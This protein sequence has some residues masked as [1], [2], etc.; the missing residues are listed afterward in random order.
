MCPDRAPS[1]PEPRPPIRIGCAGWSIASAHAA[2]FGA[3]D[4]MLARYATRF[5]T[6]EINSSFYRHHQ[7]RT[8]ER[9]AAT[10]PDGFRFSAKLPRTVTHDARL[11]GARDVLARFL[12][13]IAALGHK[14]GGVLVQL[15]PSLRYDATVAEAFLADLRARYAGPVCWEPRHATWFEPDVGALWQR[16]GVARVAADPARV[17]DAARVA[18]HGAWHYWRW[19]GS[20]RIYYSAY[21]PSA[22]QSLADELIAHAR[23]GHEA[24]CILDNTA[25]GHATTDA[26]QL[27]ALCGVPLPEPWAPAQAALPFG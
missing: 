27:Q 6:V 11:I 16:Y 1:N 2:L 26:A 9:W 3:G 10:V 25:M 21:E 8:Y 12:D 19:H 20:P 4:S 24:W 17:P 18:G 5:D 23:P 7:P 15:P 13:E 22:L 14:L